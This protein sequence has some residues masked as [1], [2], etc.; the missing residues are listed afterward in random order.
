MD[1]HAPQGEAADDAPLRRALELR[2]ALRSGAY[3]AVTIGLAL[4][5]A[6]VTGM[7]F[8]IVDLGAEAG[9]TLDQSVALFPPIAV[10]GVAA[11]LLAGAAIDRFRLRFVL[12]VYL[13]GLSV[14]YGA[15]AGLDDPALRRAALAG[16]G[17]ANGCFSTLTTV[18]A[19]KLFGRTH[20]GAISSAQ[21]SALVLASAVGPSLFAWSR[22]AT[23]SY[24]TALVGGACL[25]LSVLVTALLSRDPGG[26]RT[27]W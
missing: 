2:H 7:T 26:E 8:H 19:A 22:D 6:L 17:I 21:M 24:S 20:L 10:I 4:Q 23:G 11:G 18:A 14:G 13:L 25:P 9:L 1:G 5:S 3:W 15:L 16:L 12:A 27:V